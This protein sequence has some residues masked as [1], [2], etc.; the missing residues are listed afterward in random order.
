MEVCDHD[1]NNYLAMVHCGDVV[2]AIQFHVH[3]VHHVHL[4]RNDQ[5]QKVDDVD[6]GGC[7]R[8]L[9]VLKQIMIK[10]SNFKLTQYFQFTHNAII[11]RYTIL[12]RIYFVTY[13]LFVYY[14]N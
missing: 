12:I 13:E 7:I 6:S 11:K 3:H 14:S 4:V 10:W 8:V 1:Q 9:E 2:N 5:Y